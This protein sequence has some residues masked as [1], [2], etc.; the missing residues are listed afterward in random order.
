V[1]ADGRDP[2]RVSPEGDVAGM[3]AWSPDGTRIAYQGGRIGETTQHVFVVEVD[4]RAVHQLTSSG[5]DILPVWSADGSLI[6][7]GHLAAG[8]QDARD[9]DVWVMRSDGSSAREIA[10][11]TNDF[12]FKHGIPSPTP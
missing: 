4:G 12:D 9:V 7:Y 5:S 6:A 10:T 1:D 3:P 8:G 11:G 2:V